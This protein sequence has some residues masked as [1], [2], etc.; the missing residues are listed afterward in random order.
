VKEESKTLLYEITKVKSEVRDQVVVE[1]RIPLDI[2]ISKFFCF[3]RT[4][5]DRETL[6]NSIATFNDG[7][8]RINNHEDVWKQGFIILE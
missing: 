2:T 1:L 6:V 7:R 8:A 5:C 4:P 3:A